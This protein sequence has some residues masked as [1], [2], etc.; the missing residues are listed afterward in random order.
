MRSYDCDYRTNATANVAFL[1][2][3]N[4]TM[5]RIH[6][7]DEIDEGNVYPRGRKFDIPTNL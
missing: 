1:N 7:A 5:K 6:I 2:V 3:I 4:H